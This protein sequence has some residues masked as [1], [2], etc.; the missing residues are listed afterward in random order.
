MVNPDTKQTMFEDF[1]SRFLLG[2][3]DDVV[4]GEVRNGI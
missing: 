2:S 1:Q 3:G 4:D